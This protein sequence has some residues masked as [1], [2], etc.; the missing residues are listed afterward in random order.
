MPESGF[1]LICM[2]AVRRQ[3]CLCVCLL[4]DASTVETTSRVCN[5]FLFISNLPFSSEMQT[6]R[7]RSTRHGKCISVSTT[8]AF[9]PKAFVQACGLMEKAFT[10]ASAH[11][12]EL[13]YDFC[14]LRDFECRFTYEL[15]GFFLLKSHWTRGYCLKAFSEQTSLWTFFHH[16]FT[17]NPLTTYCS[18][19]SRFNNFPFTSTVWSISAFFIQPAIK[20]LAFTIAAFDTSRIMGINCKRKYGNSLRE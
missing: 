2:K 19:A 1:L 11:P 13:E 4:K 5:L 15:K 20:I 16:L 17:F 18:P 10:S 7:C 3:C 8:F 9:V 12:F 6:L 14:L